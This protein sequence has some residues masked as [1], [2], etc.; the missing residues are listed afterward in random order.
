[1]VL[2]DG[3]LDAVPREE[4]VWALGSV[5]A[6]HRLPF[7]ADLLAREFPPPCTRATIVSAGRALGLRIKSARIKVKAIEQQAFPLLVGLRAPSMS[8]RRR[9]AEPRTR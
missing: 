1:M 2:G 7:A 6:L 4:L 9:R 5:C 8:R 3:A